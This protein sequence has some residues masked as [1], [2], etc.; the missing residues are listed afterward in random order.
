MVAVVMIC[1]YISDSLGFV[2]ITFQ[3]VIETYHML[4]QGVPNSFFTF[5]SIDITYPTLFASALI[6]VAYLFFYTSAHLREKGFTKEKIISIIL[7]NKIKTF[8][9]ASASIVFGLIG[10]Q[11]CYY[12][13]QRKYEGFGEPQ[14]EKYFLA[15][16][17]FF[18]LI[19]SFLFCTLYKDK[20]EENSTS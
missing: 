19:F 4:I 7:K 12:K 6:P 10:M 15:F 2:K 11:H 9:V 18:V 14:Y 8:L 1:I 13:F 16:W 17:I 3:D 5:N 20:Q